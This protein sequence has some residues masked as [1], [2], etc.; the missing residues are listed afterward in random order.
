MYSILIVLGNV[1]A[2]DKTLLQYNIDIYY[3][4]TI[5]NVSIW[6]QDD[7]NILHIAIYCDILQYTV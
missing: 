4:N 1:A 3:C 6:F 5:H 7:I 2:R